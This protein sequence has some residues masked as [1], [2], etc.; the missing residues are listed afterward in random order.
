LTNVPGFSSID[1]PNGIRYSALHYTADPGK[2][3]D[4]AE[5]RKVG[6]DVRE[7][8]REMELDEA[9]WDGQPVYANYLD[10]RHCP[11]K[12][13]D[14]L[15]PRVNRS[16]YFG[17]WDA[18]QTITPAFVLLQVTPNPFQVHC[19]AEVVSNGGEPMETFCPRVMATVMQVLPGEWNEVRHYGDQTIIA[20]NGSNGT[21]AQQEAM[22]HGVSI[23]PVSNEWMARYGA[24]TWLLSRDIDEKTPGFLVDAQRCPTLRQ[25][26]QGAYQYKTATNGE[27]KGPGAVVLMPAKNAWS[28]VHDA[29]QYPA[30]KIREMVEGGGTR[31]H[32]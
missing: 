7:W 1:L 29:L 2:R 24:V 28:H 25:G 20:R 6:V 18:G 19:L 32:R 27:V 4:W 17:G 16:I 3:G 22:K 30:I 15:I 10:E 31:M 13:R 11:K 5:K 12:F 23:A 21:T 26:F 9:V 8:L 14:Q